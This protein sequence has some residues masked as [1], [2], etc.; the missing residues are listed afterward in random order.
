MTKGTDMRRIAVLLGLALA[1][2]PACTPAA[3]ATYGKQAG[4]SGSSGSSSP[5]TMLSAALAR[6][7]SLLGT[8]ITTCLGNDFDTDQLHQA[9][10]T[11]GSG[12]VVMSQTAKGGAMAVSTGTTAGSVISVKPHG[13]PSW[14]G[15]LASDPWYAVTRAKLTTTP[16]AQAIAQVL[17][18]ISPT[19]TVPT[20]NIGVDGSVSTSVFSAESFSNGG[21][22]LA[23]VTS[24]V[25]VD[26]SYHTFEAWSD[27]S[28]NVTLAID[29]T[30]IG[31]IA[32]A[33]V[34]TGAATIGVG[35][36]NQGTAANQSITVD[37][38]AAC[39]VG[40]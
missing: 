21:A 12:T 16:D 17:K 15:S 22:L 36:F 35:V 33:N 40:N 29:G 24:S 2:A 3:A 37:R 11:A 19:G 20:I 13:P 32:L 9:T 31:T 38:W 23:T 25:T 8:S 7:Q 39:V 28:T 34:G 1:A 4:G 6:A 18:V 30:S 26:T 27:G 10:T 5:A 14:I